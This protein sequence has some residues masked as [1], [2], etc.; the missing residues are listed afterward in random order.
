[1]VSNQVLGAR[2]TAG[3]MALAL[4]LCGCMH[5]HEGEQAAPATAPVAAS[6]ASAAAAPAED[7]TATEA[8]I[9]A[10]G[11]GQAPT[12]SAA[13]RVPEVNPSAP[14]HYVVKRGDTLWGI[15]SMYLKDPW[16]WP[17]VWIINPQVPNPHLIY[18]GD[19]L[20]LAYGAD[21]RPQ[22][23]LEQAGTV[24]LD[25]RL[26]SSPLDNEIPTIPYSAIAAFLSR[27]SVMTSEDVRNAPYVLAFRDLHQVGGSGME[28]Y[29][30]H[31]SAT[32]SSRFAVMHVEGPLRDPDD[33]AVV[34]Y[35]GIYTAT[36]LVQRP[37]EP[38]KAL[39]IDPARETV[40][41]DR[42]LSASAEDTPTTFTPRPPATPV[43]G[44]IINVVGGTDLAGQYAGLV[45]QFEVCVINRGK[46]HGLE[47][48]SVLAVY[49]AGDVVT[50]LYR[51]GM[52]IGD[53]NHG[54]R[55]F[56]PSVRLPDER[57]G[58]L[59]V[60]KVYDRVSFGLII[61]ASDAIYTGDVV[62]NP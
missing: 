14:K 55:Q 1:M 32:Q 4:S 24:R 39:L 35:T 8:G 11:A 21:G 62:R 48:G 27:P 50:D 10:A 25:P 57:A 20:A 54:G 7:M 46:R 40:A 9:A 43:Q 61:G 18:P 59:L 12:A 2:A 34:G 38:A 49:G 36:A 42:L 51:H 45:G 41:G 26:R 58:T 22:V 5:L 33:G 19:T 56:A 15:A 30:R 6:P 13:E 31:L 29:V 44:R 47:P 16:L 53:S 52:Q 3:L 37:G 60:F 28:V 17:E 23:S